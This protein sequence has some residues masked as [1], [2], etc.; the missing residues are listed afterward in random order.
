MT[1]WTWL[2]T[3]TPSLPVRITLGLLI[4]LTLALLDYRRHR[5]H[6]TRW[7]EYLI[8]LLC[9]LAAMAYGVLNDQITSTISWEYFYYGKD[10]GKV[11]GPHTPP[12]PLQLHLHAAL[13][14]IQATWTAGL[15]IGV[16]LLFANNPSKTLP[17]LPHKT[18]LKFLPLIML[19]TATVAALGAYLGYTAHLTRF[20]DD[21]PIMLKDNLWRPRRFMAVYGIHLGGY[22]GGLLSLLITV[23]L[24]LHKRRR[25]QQGAPGFPVDHF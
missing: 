15:I 18:L 20:N 4:L 6:A 2:T 7:R 8:L 11:L 25:L 9:T 19:I 5:Q 3:H 21:F 13:V 23:P 24:I 12:D 1:P 14:G 22:L 16:A 10:L 17:E